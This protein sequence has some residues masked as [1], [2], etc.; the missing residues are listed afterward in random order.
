MKFTPEPSQLF[1]GQKI[2]IE[3]LK[4]YFSPRVTG[5]QLNRRYFLLYGMGGI[6]KTQ[7]CLKWLEEASNQ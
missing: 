5:E 2:Y 7:I 3:R 4:K 1:T 6:G